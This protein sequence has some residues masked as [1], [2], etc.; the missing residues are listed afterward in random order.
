MEEG[1]EAPF[2]PS[3]AAARAGSGRGGGSAA[4]GPCH[5]RCRRQSRPRTATCGTA[6]PPRL[7]SASSSPEP[8]ARYLT[9]ATNPAEKDFGVMSDEKQSAVRVCSQPREPTASCAESKAAWAAGQ[10]TGSSSS[11]LPFWTQTGVLCTVLVQ[12][13]HLQ[14]KK[15]IELLEQIQRWTTKLVGGLEHLT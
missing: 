14:H 8:R 5:C 10:E 9:V 7:L 2:R 4:D 1:S 13:L 11:T 6:P 15:D 12:F 3:R